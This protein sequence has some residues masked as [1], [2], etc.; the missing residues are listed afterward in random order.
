VSR[1]ALLINTHPDETHPNVALPSIGIGENC[2]PVI[3]FIFDTQYCRVFVLLF[4]QAE[5]ETALSHGDD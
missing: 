4:T 2:T 3:G 5:N 1:S